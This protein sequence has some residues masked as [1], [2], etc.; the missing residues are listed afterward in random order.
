MLILTDFV[1]MLTGMTMVKYYVALV[2]WYLV[3]Y[4]LYCDLWYSLY[5]LASLVPSL[6]SRQW[7]VKKRCGTT[8]CACKDMCLE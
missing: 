3:F 6:D 7:N 5:N 1:V 4:L 2:L 8:C